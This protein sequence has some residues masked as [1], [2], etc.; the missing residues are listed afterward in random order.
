MKVK[1]R[2]RASSPTSS[3]SSSSSPSSVARRLLLLLL[4][5]SRP[6]FTCTCVPSWSE[7]PTKWKWRAPLLETADSMDSIWQPASKK[8]SALP[9]L[10]CAG[11]NQM[12][13]VC[14][15]FVLSTC[16]KRERERQQNCKADT[17]PLTHLNSRKLDYRS[18]W[19]SSKILLLLLLLLLLILLQ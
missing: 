2:E 14:V 18:I 9:L 7:T 17:C 16:P 10:Y 3:V 1:K 15:L 12:L 6:H 8:S 4:N 13:C 5:T 11:L 19:M